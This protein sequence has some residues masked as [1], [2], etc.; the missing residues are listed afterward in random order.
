[1]RLPLPALVLVFS[2]LVFQPHPAAGQP[3]DSFN[4]L[5][6]LK[7]DLEKRHGIVSLECFPF[8]TAVGDNAGQ[9]Q[10]VSRCLQ[11]AETLAAALNRVPDADL[12]EVGI[13]TRFLRTAG[14]HTLLVP[15]DAPGAAMENAL[16]GRA[17]PEAQ[18]RVLERVRELKRT[19]FTNFTFRELYCTKTISNDQCLQG[20]ETLAAI[21]P[22]GI[23]S[24]KQWG[25]VVISDTL[26][27]GP[28]PSL[29]LLRFDQPAAEMKERL[30][31]NKAQTFWEQRRRVYEEMQERF[32]KGFERMLQVPNVFCAPDLSGDECLQGAATLHTLSRDPALRARPWGRVWINRHNTL[33]QSD[34]DAALKFDLPA[35][36]A[37]TVFMNKPTRAEVADAVT[38]SEEL[39]KKVKNNSAGLRAVCDLNGLRSALCVQGFETFVA[40]LKAHRDYRVAP[41]WDN[42]MFVDGTQLD[43]V[44]FALNSSSR[45][46]YLYVNVASGV[47]ELTRFL[48]RFKKQ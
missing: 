21:A 45:D 6:V 25:P 8:L 16:G 26:V 43:R 19:I 38:R 11:G 10:W 1:V 34:Y 32:G 37:K 22:E 29:L 24:R 7:A 23:L 9:A 39:E 20:Y 4:R 42:L 27:P 17:L 12:K 33:I 13:S 44:N 15:W 28:D 40:F 5:V 46:T 35:E 3:A 48:D 18:E 2:I 14:F 41:P 30:L 36:Q 47:E 31:T